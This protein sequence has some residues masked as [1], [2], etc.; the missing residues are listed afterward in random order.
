MFTDKPGVPTNL[1]VLSKTTNSI[2]L[3]WSAPLDKTKYSINS[4]IIHYRILEEISAKKNTSAT[5]SFNLTNLITGKTYMIH[6]TAKNMFFEGDSSNPINVTTRA[7]G[8]LI[9][10]VYLYLM[11][12]RD[13]QKFPVIHHLIKFTDD[14]L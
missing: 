13:I 10:S 5:T 6:I 9:F 1:M 8:T 12:G 4:Y 2:Y 3:Q 7:A 14:N 11:N